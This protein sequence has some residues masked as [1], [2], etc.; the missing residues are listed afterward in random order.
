MVTENTK[1]KSVEKN[2]NGNG[3]GLFR[4]FPKI[5]VLFDILPSEINSAFFRKILNLN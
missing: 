4:S 5:T 1:T 3:L 2:G